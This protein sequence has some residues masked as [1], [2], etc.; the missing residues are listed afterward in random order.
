MNTPFIAPETLADR[1]RR[2]VP[3]AVKKWARRVKPATM[4]SAF[5]RVYAQDIWE[6]GSGRG[7]TAENT[8]AYRA[9]LEQFLRDQDVKS[10][11]DLGC[12]DWQFSQ[13]VD[14]QGADYHGVDTVPAVVQENKR[15][16][17]HRARFSHLDIS[18]EALPSADL[19]LIK[20]VLQHWPTRT[21]RDFLP[22]LK[23]YRWAI[24]TNCGLSG[25]TLNGDIAMT[26]YRPLDLRQPPFGLPATSEFWFR[27]DEVAP[28]VKNKL[29]LVLDL[30]QL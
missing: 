7:S 16:F 12:G 14:W 6:G 10:V 11:V 30:K 17:G 20:D 1:L 18:Q 9:F 8:V 21:I 27:T 3:P 2:R 15:R 29:V 19:V 25:P 22:R 24:I 28:G 13:H 5:S 26:G 23:T 4:T